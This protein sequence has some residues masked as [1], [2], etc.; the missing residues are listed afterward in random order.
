[1]S[2]RS[3]IV[4]DLDSIPNKIYPDKLNFKVIIYKLLNLFIIYFKKIYL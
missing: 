3:A 1:M 4:R 2:E